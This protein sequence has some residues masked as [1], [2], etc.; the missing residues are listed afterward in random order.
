MKRILFIHTSSRIGGAS[1]CLLNIIKEIPR[2]EFSIYVA[3]KNEGPLVHELRKLDIE[4][5]IHPEIMDVPYNKNFFLPSSINQYYKVFKSKKIIKKIIN[6]FCIDLLY[7]NTM[8]LY[9]YLSIGYEMRIKTVI[10]VREHWPI[11]Q[12]RLQLRFAQK[13]VEKYATHLFAINKYSLSIFANSSRKASIVYDWIDMSN[14]YEERPFDN[15]FQEDT[16]KL[17]VLLYTGGFDSMKGVYEVVTSFSKVLT[18]DNYRLLILGGGNIDQGNGFKH[19]IKTLL[20]K[21]GYFYYSYE[22]SK[23]IKH[24]N[25]IKCIPA[26]YKLNHIIE[27][28]FGFISFFTVP[29]ANL[30]L[31][32]NIILG[33]PCLAVRT[34]ESEEYTNDGEYALL[35]PF[36]NI[37]EFEKNLRKFVENQETYRINAQKGSNHLKSLFSKSDNKNRLITVLRNI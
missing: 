33:N 28:S 2:E 6:D 17:K 3:L 5:I 27:Q 14:R 8:M 11:N 26:T 9:Q 30:A 25:R 35:T 36:G 15:I 21:I 29:H 34:A 37:P 23:A 24:D 32:E 18:E 31:A 12:H 19:T 1:Y 22:L 4:V 10:H 13:Y 16:S 20:Q 7:L